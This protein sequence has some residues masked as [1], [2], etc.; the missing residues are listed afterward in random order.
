MKPQWLFTELV[1]FIVSSPQRHTLWLVLVTLPSWAVCIK[2]RE[3]CLVESPVVSVVGKGV[4]L[5]M[6]SRRSG[7]HPYFPVRIEGEVQFPFHTQS[8][9]YSFTWWRVTEHSPLKVVMRAGKVSPANKGTCCKTWVWFLGWP[10]RWKERTNPCRVSSVPHAHTKAH[11]CPPQIKC[12]QKG[13][14][15]M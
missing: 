15:V 9:I 8:E 1:S 5:E 6:Q 7:F 13:S 12:N 3:W 2:M 4:W 11:A 10:T 14:I